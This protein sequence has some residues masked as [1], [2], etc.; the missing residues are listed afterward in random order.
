MQERENCSWRAFFAYK[1]RAESNI[2]GALNDP[3][4]HVSAETIKSVHLMEW[5]LGRQEDI[6]GKYDSLLSHT[7]FPLKIALELWHNS[8]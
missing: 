7:F 5:D 3:Q 6:L 8:Y 2:T 4:G 1:I